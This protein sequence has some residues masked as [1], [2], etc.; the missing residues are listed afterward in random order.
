MTRAGKKSDRRSTL[1][2]RALRTV[3][4]EGVSVF[5]FFMPGGQVTKVADIS[6][7]ERDEDDDALKGFQRREIRNHVRSIVQYLDQGRVLFPNAIIL[8]MS[9]DVRFT[10]SRGPAPDALLKGVQAGMLTIPVRP[11]GER[12]A[13]IVDGQ[14]RSLAL[15]E[16]N[17]PELPVPVVGFVSDDLT[18]QREQFILV[19]KAR[20]LPTRLINELLPETGG[21][22]L[23]RDLAAR[24]I[25][26]ELCSLLNRDKKSPFYKLIKRLSEANSDAVVT[27][28]AVVKMIRNSISSPLG[29]LAPFKP[30]GDESADIP[31]MYR[32]LRT[33]WSAVKDVFADA[34]GVPP[35]KSRLMHSAGIEAMGVL[36]DR[37]Y[38]RHS[39][40]PDEAEA[41]RHDL[42]KMA[43]YCHWTEGSWETLGVEWN[44]IQ[45]TPKHI[46]VLSE[47][48]VRIHSTRVPR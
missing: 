32:T 34:W 2:V 43:R 46:R 8:A 38:A 45:N 31:A 41:I 42:E 33:F 28:T 29:A 19:N 30:A 7:V 13:W 26:S 37:V 36:M 4:G 22:V 15:S 11:E 5:A 24:K 48:L 10:G 1:L 9:P 17:S 40:K 16:S 39:G 47:A 12:V 21:V 20:P 27:D 25:P 44:E 18:I 6:R 35:T 23:P 14:Q 3:Q